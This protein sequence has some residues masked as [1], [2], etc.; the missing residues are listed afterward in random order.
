MFE[1]KGKAV[2]PLFYEVVSPKK[3][4]VEALLAHRGSFVFVVFNLGAPKERGALLLG[5]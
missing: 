1:A 4:S 3:D 2:H 5:F